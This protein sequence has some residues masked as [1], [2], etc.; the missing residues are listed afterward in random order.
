MSQCKV[1]AGRDVSAR[2]IDP[3]AIPASTRPRQTCFDRALTMHAG[4]LAGLPARV[5][6]RRMVFFVSVNT[7]QVE[8]SVFAYGPFFLRASRLPAHLAHVHLGRHVLYDV[9]DDAP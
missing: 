7:L 2:K 3:G 5:P 1:F 8:G 9:I 6:G 4:L